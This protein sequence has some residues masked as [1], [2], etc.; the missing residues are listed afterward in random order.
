MASILDIYASA[1]YEVYDPH[2]I[3]RVWEISKELDALLL[4]HEA[5]EWAFITPYNPYPEK[6][7]DNENMSRFLEIQM[8]TVPYKSYSWEWRG[9]D[10]HPCTPE[11]SILII[12]ISR[13]EAEKVGN[14]FWQKAI[15]GGV[16]GGP[17]E[18]VVLFD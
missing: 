15:L 10:D 14:H 7:T 1:I 11:K 17:V 12:G 3:L 2:I 4:E 16:R 6:L 13:G 9:D 5:S 8:M 18:L